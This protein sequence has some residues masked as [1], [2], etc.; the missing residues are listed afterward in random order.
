MLVVP[1]MCELLLSILLLMMTDKGTGY[2][3]SAVG[4]LDLIVTPVG[5]S[6]FRA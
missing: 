6:V 3:T 2:R 4:L 5:A 1:E